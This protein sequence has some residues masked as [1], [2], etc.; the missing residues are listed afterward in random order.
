MI[1]HREM[2]KKIIFLTSLLLASTWTQSCDNKFPGH[3]KAPAINHSNPGN[4]PSI[5]TCRKDRNDQYNLCRC[6]DQ[7]GTEVMEDKKTMATLFCCQCPETMDEAYSE[8]KV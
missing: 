7:S 3:T 8:F 1:E 5:T 2:V 6:F 4:Q